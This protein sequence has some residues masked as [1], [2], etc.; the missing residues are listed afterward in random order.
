MN[1]PRRFWIDMQDADDEANYAGTALFKHPRQGPVL[2]QE[3]LFE[4][5]EYSAYQRLERALA[6]W[7]KEFASMVPN[8]EYL[9]ACDRIEA[10]INQSAVG[11]EGEK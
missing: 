4:V 8:H 1:K 10:I 9:A 7:K 6:L 5:I 11:A 2:W 3:T